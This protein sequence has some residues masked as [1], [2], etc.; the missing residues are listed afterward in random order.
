[1]TIEK[2]I[3]SKYLIADRDF[4][5]E[6]LLNSKETI[7]NFNKEDRR[8][9]EIETDWKGFHTFNK[10]ISIWKISFYENFSVAFVNPV[11]EVYSRL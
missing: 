1:M 7:Y 10:H 8:I 5:I 3:C 6:S 11:N 9:A 4:I 2:M